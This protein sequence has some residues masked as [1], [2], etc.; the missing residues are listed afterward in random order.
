[1]VSNLNILEKIGS[2]EINHVFAHSQRLN[3]EAIVDFVKALYKVSMDSL[4]QL[5]MKFLE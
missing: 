4:R 5:A 1:L 2:F 3:S